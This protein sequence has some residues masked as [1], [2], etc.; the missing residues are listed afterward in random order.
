M[1]IFSRESFLSFAQHPVDDRFV[2]VYASIEG[3]IEKVF[4]GVEVGHNRNTDHRY[5]AVVPIE[6]ASVALLNS[7]KDINYDD[8]QSS[9]EDLARWHS[10]VSVWV[11]M[12]E[13]QER[14]AADVVNREKAVKHFDL[15]A[16]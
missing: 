4:P 15:D 12:F 16:I 14:R 10:Y 2:V 7:L 6:R 11:T 5:S 8:L 13:E 3:D 1:W 9:V